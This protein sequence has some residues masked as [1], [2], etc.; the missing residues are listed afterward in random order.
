MAPHQL[1]QYRLKVG[2]WPLKSQ[3]VSSILRTDSSYVRVTRKA[4]EQIATLLY[5]GSTPIM[6]S[7]YA[8]LV[9]WKNVCPIS[10]MS[11]VRI[12]DQAPVLG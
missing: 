8:R 10:G 4:R 12:L 6:H 9:Q 3:I 7:S 2:R 1:Y 11:E 5:V